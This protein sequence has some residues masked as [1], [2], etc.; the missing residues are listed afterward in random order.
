MRLIQAAIWASMAMAP[1][2]AL[3]ANLPA[4]LPA[5][6]AVILGPDADALRRYTER[7]PVLLGQDDR[8][9][10]GQ[11]LVVLYLAPDGATSLVPPQSIFQ[12]ELPGCDPKASITC[13]TGQGEAPTT[14]IF[15]FVGWINSGLL[16]PARPEGGTLAVRVKLPE[17]V[18][19]RVADAAHLT[20]PIVRTATK[21]GET[22]ALALVSAALSCPNNLNNVCRDAEAAIDRLCRRTS[23]SKRWYDLIDCGTNIGWVRSEES[24]D[25]N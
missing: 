15:T 7:L 16:C 17:D 3:A 25:C 12:P 18:S 24:C 23:S 1:I 10:N 21:E 9:E 6:L 2:A 5:R 19:Q 11:D 22:R 4:E 8:Q 13:C 14:W 20:S